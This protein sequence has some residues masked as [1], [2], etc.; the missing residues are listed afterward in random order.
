MGPSPIVAVAVRGGEGRLAWRT[1]A[2]T[3]FAIVLARPELWLIG[4]LS[5]IARGGLLLLTAP[6]V[7]LPSPVGLG[8]LLGPEVLGGSTAALG[9]LVVG[10]VAGAAAL[11]LGGLVLAASADLM[12]YERFVRDPESL[13]VRAGREP[14]RLSPR[15]RLSTVFSLVGIQAVAL[16]PAIVAAV[17]LGEWAA[18]LIRG[19]LLSPSSEVPLLARLAFGAR[20][21]IV[22]LIMA[23]LVAEIVGSIASRHLLA[24]RFG[25]ARDRRPVTEAR[26]LRMAVVQALAAPVLVAS[27]SAGAW[28]IAGLLVLPV[29]GALVI[30]WGEVRRL[31][32]APVVLEAEVGGARL[33]ITLAFASLWIAVMLMAGLASAIRGALATAASFR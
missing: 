20:E 13:E 33:L 29:A 21:P 14:R 10:A 17:V 2:S 15:C 12:A 3:V 18:V 19:E 30:A 5:M 8:V 24:S 26:S 16:V 27:R 6:L 4:A 11:L 22:A 28:L 32:L 31:Y 25:L 23:L 9:E 1:T 7:T